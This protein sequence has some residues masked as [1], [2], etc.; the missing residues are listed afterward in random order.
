[1]VIAMG[2]G[3]GLTGWC[4]ARFGAACGAHVATGVAVAV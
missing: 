4:V 3:W 2:V 1:V